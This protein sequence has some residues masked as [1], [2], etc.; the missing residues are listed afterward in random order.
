[1]KNITSENNIVTSILRRVRV[2]KRRF[3]L[4]QRLNKIIFIQNV[5]K[6]HPRGFGPCITTLEN[7]P[8]CGTNYKTYK[9]PSILACYQRYDPSK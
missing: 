2:P 7:R 4:N 3:I 9:N 6:A 1:Y 8:V 5:T